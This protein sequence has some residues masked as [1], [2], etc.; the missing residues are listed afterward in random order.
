MSVRKVSVESINR[1]Y[2]RSRCVFWNPKKKKCMNREI[3]RKTRRCT[4]VLKP[5]FISYTDVNKDE[6]EMQRI[7]DIR[8]EYQDRHRKLAEDAKQAVGNESL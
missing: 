6:E 3:P 5:C 2:V 1:E 4:T 8:K 7:A